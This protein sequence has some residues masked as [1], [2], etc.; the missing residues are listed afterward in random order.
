[1]FYVQKN[2]DAFLIGGF[3]STSPDRKELLPHS[4]MRRIGGGDK[5]TIWSNNKNK[6]P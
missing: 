4:T 5:A 2:I 1:M 3:S 6:N